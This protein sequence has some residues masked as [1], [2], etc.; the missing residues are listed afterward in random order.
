MKNLILTSNGDTN[1]DLDAR[2]TKIIAML[3]ICNDEL[4]MISSD[5][6][7]M[8]MNQYMYIFSEWYTARKYALGSK[9]SQKDR[10]NH[11]YSYVPI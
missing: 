4:K 11:I 10:M 3:H 6:N 7:D 1:A 9:L 5:T 2:M 8:V